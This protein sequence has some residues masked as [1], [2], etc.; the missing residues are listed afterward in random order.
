MLPD[1]TKA[2]SFQHVW[3]GIK[4]ATLSAEAAGTHLGEASL[5]LVTSDGAVSDRFHDIS[6]KWSQNQSGK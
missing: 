6:E 1:K 3:K 4:E 2:L 5:P